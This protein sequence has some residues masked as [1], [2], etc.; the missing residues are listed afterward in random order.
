MGETVDVQ[1]AAGVGG[2]DG[3]RAPRSGP[4]MKSSFLKS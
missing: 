2:P 1:H 4:M 3:G